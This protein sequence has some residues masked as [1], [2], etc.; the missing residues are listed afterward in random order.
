MQAMDIRLPGVT[1]RLLFPHPCHPAAWL[2]AA[3]P[4]CCPLAV[5]SL[6]QAITGA[7]LLEFRQ[8]SAERGRSVMEGV[9]RNYPKR[10]DLWSVYIDQVCGGRPWRKR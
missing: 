1:A 3:S 6:L 4:H 7:A 9:L 10:L 5:P 2:S 8:G